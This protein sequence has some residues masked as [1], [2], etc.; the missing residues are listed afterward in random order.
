MPSACIVS[1]VSVAPGLSTTPDPAPVL[2]LTGIC[3]RFA[4]VIA[5]NDVG[6][7]VRAGEVMAL[8]GENDAGTIRINGEEVVF[9]SAQRA[10][11]QS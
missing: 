3:K 10:C 7:T 11:T 2:Q 8:I 6:L 1:D 9:G 4:G 5:L